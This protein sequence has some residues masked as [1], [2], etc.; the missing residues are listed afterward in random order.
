M[1]TDGRKITGQLV[2]C[3]Q[4]EKFGFNARTHVRKK[5]RKKAFSVGLN[6][7]RTKTAEE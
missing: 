1:H 3:I 2:K 5:S 4:R 7:N 6:I